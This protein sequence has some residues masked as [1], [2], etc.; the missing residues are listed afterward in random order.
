MISNSSSLLQAVYSSSCN[1]KPSKYLPLALE[2]PAQPDF[3][4]TSCIHRRL[5]HHHHRQTPCHLQTVQGRRDRRKRPRDHCLHHRLQ[6]RQ[7]LTDINSFSLISTPCKGGLGRQTW[8]CLCTSVGSNARVEIE[9][10]WSP[11]CRRGSHWEELASN[12]Y[13]FSST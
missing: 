3:S 1:S 13:L 10:P 8:R 4:W 11:P 9:G 7:V 5:P 2:A 6:R 12:T